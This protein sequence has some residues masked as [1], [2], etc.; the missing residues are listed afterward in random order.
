MA[1]DT[2]HRRGG[3]LPAETTSFIGRKREIAQIAEVLDR[4]RLV[5]LT[6]PGGVGKTRTA[7][8]AAHQLRDRSPDG[9]HLVPLS[10]LAE[11]ELLPNTVAAAL[12]LPEQ[13]A[14]P[15]ME[16][17]TA[18]LAD[19][20]ALI[21]LDTCEHLIDACA[22]LADELLCAA[23]DVRLIATS[24]QPL[25]IAG[26]H[27]LPIPPL[28]VEDDPDPAARCGRPGPRS[29]ALQLFADRT[30]A[31]VPGFTLTDDNLADATSLCR[32]LDGIPLAIELAVSR[33]RALSLEEILGRLD[34]RFLLL[35]GGRRTT[36]PRHQTLRTT[37]GWSHD[38]STPQERVLWARLSVFAGEFS[39]E[40]AEGV[41]AD[42][43]VL[44]AEEVLDALFGLVEKSVV[45]RVETE[46]GTRYRML[47]T[48]REFGRDQL[49]A[50]AEE[51]GLRRRH[52]AYFLDRAEEFDAAWTGD[53]QLSWVR[54]FRYDQANLRVALET[55]TGT[56][57]LAYDGL[58]LA[59]RLWGYWQCTGLYTEG[60]YWLRRALDVSREPTPERVKALWLT[61]WY[62]DVQG[63]RGDNWALLDEAEEIAARAGD[64]RGLAWTLAYRHHAHYFRGTVEG[65]AEGYEDARRRM[66]EAGDEVALLITAFQFAFAHFLAG[67]I[68][69]GIALCDESLRRNAAHPQ[70]HWSRSWALWVKSVGL[71]LKGESAQSIECCRE[72]IRSKAALRDTM[73]IA[74]FLEGFAWYAAEQGHFERVGALQGAADALWRKAAKE[75]R[76]AIPVL[77]E[78]HDNAAALAREAL[79]ADAFHRAFTEGGSL[80][81]AE[82]VE[83]A[84]DEDFTKMPELPVRAGGPADEL[85]PRER[86]VAALVTRGLTNRE[87]AEKLVVSK[88]TVDSHIEHILAKLGFSS[89]AQIAALQDGASGP[90]QQ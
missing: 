36:V 9:V 47:D 39:L 32:R 57:G 58:C 69:E 26:E 25:D 87:I 84:L 74:H 66:A 63:E 27:I 76:F 14:R 6:G 81:L 31:A 77:H 56:P 73:G 85:T 83:L 2:E 53:T 78:L 48:I 43:G 50:G 12:D 61:S 11:P 46:V 71:W 18:Y 24:R 13:A 5:T 30:A 15:A 40:A 22:L 89:R 7:V 79:G 42:D 59:T 72:G 28:S 70:E 86:Q 10:A 52:A 75:A 38:L 68:G 65:V 90:R 55:C 34:R 1:E 33:L 88:R 4:F 37:I 20:K 82:A 19:K 80:T 23:P 49:A 41:C 29:D 16:V 54:R 35:T 45:L 21:I 67:G 44:P 8:R 64:A 60:R 17:L 3:E 51:A 62:L